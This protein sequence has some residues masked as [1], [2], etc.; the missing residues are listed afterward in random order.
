[1]PRWPREAVGRGVDRLS[2][3][4]GRGLMYARMV[5][6]ATEGRLPF[7]GGAIAYTGTLKDEILTNGGGADSY[8]VVE[9]LWSEAERYKP[10][11]DL[12]QKMTYLELRQRLSELLL[13]RQDKMTMATSVEARVPFLDHHFVEFVMALPPEMKV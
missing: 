8:A 6:D 1:M 11:A 10:D 3:R 5:R 4:V 7:W 12:Y 2:R 13:M 9:R